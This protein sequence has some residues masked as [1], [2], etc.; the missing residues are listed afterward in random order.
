MCQ[1]CSVITKIIRIMDTQKKLQ[2]RI[3]YR[4]KQLRR[5]ELEIEEKVA[6]LRAL[7]KQQIGLR[8]ELAAI[9]DAR[10][11]IYDKWY[12]HHRE[13]N[14]DYDVMWDT[15]KRIM[16]SEGYESEFRIVEG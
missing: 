1:L 14:S 3:D 2:E 4:E 12:R 15:E 8:D 9:K 16:L 7:Q 6:E 10:G 13:D 5:F 11:G